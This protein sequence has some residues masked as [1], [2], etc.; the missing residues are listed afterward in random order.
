MKKSRPAHWLPQCASMRGGIKTD[1][2]MK[3]LN[4][5]RFLTDEHPMI[6]GFVYSLFSCCC[7]SSTT[8]HRYSGGCSYAFRLS[9]A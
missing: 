8:S 1:E 3:V 9:L 4:Q 6:A 5:I 2:T 7:C